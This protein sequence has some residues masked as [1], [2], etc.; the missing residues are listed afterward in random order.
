MSPAAKFNDDVDGIPVAS[1]G[2]TDK[3]PAADGATTVTFNN[4]P[5]APAGTTA[6]VICSLRDTPDTNGPDKPTPVRV[7]RTRSGVTVT[8]DDAGPDAAF[9]ATRPPPPNVTATAA[10]IA[11]HRDRHN[12]RRESL[13]V[14]RAATAPP[15]VHRHAPAANRPPMIAQRRSPLAQQR[16][17]TT[18]SRPK[19]ET[20]Q[21]QTYA[22]P[23][24][25][26]SAVGPKRP[27]GDRH[28]R[29]T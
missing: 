22:T 10:P 7:S 6:L 9:T 23:P 12:P 27:D 5:V 8:T 24:H 19:S 14:V 26:Q 4:T 2:R 28:L 3:N 11:A 17:V 25:H 29:R 18:T 16:Q 21:P 1:P 15:R 13:P 20:D